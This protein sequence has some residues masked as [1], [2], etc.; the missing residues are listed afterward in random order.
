ML[1]LA[2]RSQLLP[3]EKI[4]NGSHIEVGTLVS[5]GVCE[6]VQLDLDHL[7][8]FGSMRLA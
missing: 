3:N 2:S 7:G 8:T 6:L 1:V 4:T 5:E